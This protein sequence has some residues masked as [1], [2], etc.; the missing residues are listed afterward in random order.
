LNNLNPWEDIPLNRQFLC[1][2][3]NKYNFW[4]YKQPVKNGYN[5]SFLFELKTTKDDIPPANKLPKFKQISFYKTQQQNSDKTFL[6]VQLLDNSKWDIFNDFVLLLIDAC[7]KQETEKEA[8]R[9][10]IQRSY[11]W[12]ALMKGGF[13]KRLS[14]EVQ[15]G[16][17]GELYFL[18]NTLFQSIGIS[19]SLDSWKGPIPQP[20]DFY[21]NKMQVEVKS[22]KRDGTSV[23]ISSEDQLE[24]IS[25]DELFLSVF[26]ISANKNGKTLTDWCY[27]LEDLITN[28]DLAD[29]NKY[30]E[31]LL[32]A[33]FEYKHD[34]S[35]KRW[36]IEEISYYS[37]TEKFP[38]IVK[39]NL[40]PGISK[41]KYLL[42]LSY[43]KE[44]KIKYELLLDKIKTSM[45]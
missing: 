10:F 35:D 19:D 31:L 21:L 20:K 7:E 40:S 37:I 3:S 4:R 23:G 6:N 27:E 22:I 25:N 36:E 5:F 43:I 30:N 12:L 24:L 15:K 2:E 17:I 11:R 38:R 26:G 42:D 32:D 1:K 18:K 41:V 28:N 39:T 33:G 45:I 16:L 8:L 9:V 13:K 29:L 14:D 44:F 34:Y